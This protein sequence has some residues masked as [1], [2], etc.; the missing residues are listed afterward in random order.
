MRTISQPTSASSIVCAMEASVSIVSQV[1]IDWTRIGFVAA[2]ADVAHHHLARDAPLI[3]K[4][5]SRSSS[6]LAGSTRTAVP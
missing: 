5:D 4:T 1:I 6:L 2:D 3:A